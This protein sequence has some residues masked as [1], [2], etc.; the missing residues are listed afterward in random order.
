MTQPG[1]AK[2]T[3]RRVH[4]YLQIALEIMGILLVAAGLGVGGAYLFGWSGGLIVSGVTVLAA[5]YL[6][7]LKLNPPAPK[8]TPPSPPPATLPANGFDPNAEIILKTWG[9]VAWLTK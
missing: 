4:E 2:I 7:E 6:G 8:V 1:S 3:I 9:R 5:A